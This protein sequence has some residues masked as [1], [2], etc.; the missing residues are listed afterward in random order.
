MEDTD[1]VR[2]QNTQ[3]P[4]IQNDGLWFSVEAARG[5]PKDVMRWIVISRIS[6]TAMQWLSL[7]ICCHENVGYLA[8]N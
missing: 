8:I 6:Y 3:S 5:Q 2:I 7:R 4:N 1:A